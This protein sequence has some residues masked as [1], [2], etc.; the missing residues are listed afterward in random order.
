MAQ[1]LQQLK[2]RIKT[3]QS[4]AQISKAMEMIAASK[5]KKAQNAVEKHNPYAIKIKKMLHRILADRDCFSKN[6]EKFIR[7][8]DGRKLVYVIS[9]DKGLCG[10]LVVNLLKK[11]IGFI[12]EKDYVVVVG[13]KAISSVVKHNYDV[14]ASFAMGTNFPKYED[15]YPMIDIAKKIYVSTSEVTKVA[16]VYTEFRNMLSQEAVINE[17]FPVRDSVDAKEK[18]VDYLFEP[19][20]EQVLKDLLPYYFEVELYAALMNA[21]ASEQASRMMSM[22]NAKDSANDI[23]A[24]L[25][26]V[27]NKSR[28][29]KITNELLDLSNGQQLK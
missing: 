7:H 17:I 27:Y 10:G 25:T 1:N 11:A 15:M 5:I 19:N 28:Q 18:Q 3:S 2:K 13:K 29:E 16:V 9:P 12:E 23:T 8:V 14:L 21:Y 20:P 22:K 4:I 24:A 6:S 26:N